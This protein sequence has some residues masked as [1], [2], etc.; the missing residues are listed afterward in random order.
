M[1]A[2]L[3]FNLPED[4]EDF[5][6]ATKASRMKY[7]LDDIYNKVFRP[8]CKYGLSEQELAMDRGELV[9]KIKCEVME[10]IN[11]HLDDCLQ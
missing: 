8:R 1:K 7:A 11:S 2:I 3:E 9:E 10:L 4:E 5:R 6:L